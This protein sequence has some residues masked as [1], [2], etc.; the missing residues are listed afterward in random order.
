MAQDYAGCIHQA[1]AAVQDTYACPQRPPQRR[2]VDEDDVLSDVEG[3]ATGIEQ[4]LAQYEAE[5]R[6]STVFIKD[7]PIPYWLA[8]RHRWPDLTQL[9]LDTFSTPTMSDEPE[10]LFSETGA[11]LSPRRR[12]MNAETMQ[13]TMCLRQW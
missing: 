10:R 11:T 12:Q 4:Q 6:H 8:Q 2:T 1:R 13:Q 5:P 3:P 9:A 7:S